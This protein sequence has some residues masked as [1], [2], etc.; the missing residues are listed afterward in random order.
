MCFNVT[1][2]S[3]YIS[4]YIGAHFL[5]G[6]LILYYNKTVFMNHCVKQ[7]QRPWNV[8]PIIQAGMFLMMAD[9][10]IYLM[11]G[12]GRLFVENKWG[13]EV[14]SKF[15]FAMSLTLLMVTFI[16]QI[17]LVLFPALK[18]LKYEKMK[19]LIIQYHKKGGYGSLIRLYSLFRCKRNTCILVTPV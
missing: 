12:I 7:K 5:R 2:Y 16:N 8:R 11:F 18:Q 6:I 10:S 17:G 14:F 13:I 4:L 19:E 15:S 9:Y 3:C 1:D